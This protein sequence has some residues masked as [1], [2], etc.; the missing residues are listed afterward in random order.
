MGRWIIQNL[1]QR[2]LIY[3]FMLL[4]MMLGNIGQSWAAEQNARQVLY[5]SSYHRGYA[6]ND[7]IEQGL[8]ERIKESNQLIDIY[9]EFLDARRFPELETSP[10]LIELFISKHSKI[11]YDAIIVSDNPAINFAVKH[12][13]R[14]FPN[15]PIV[16][17]GY[18]SFRPE[19][20]QGV[21]HITGVNEEIDFKGTIDM[22][23]KVH[24]KTKKLVFVSSDFNLNG[25]IN[26]GLVEKVLIPHYQNDY[27]IQ[28]IKN[29][30]LQDIEQALGQLPQDS[31]VFMLGPPLDNLE[32]EVL[33]PKEYYHRFSAA[34]AVP[35]YS[36]WDF[37]LN[38]GSMGGQIITGLDQGRKVVDLMLELFKNV[39]IEQ[40][41]V[42]METPTRKI[43]DFNAMQRFNISERALPADSQI[44]NK[45]DSFYQQYK[46]YIFIVIFFIVALIVLS[47][48]LGLLLRKSYWLQKQLS[49][50]IIERQKVEDNLRKSQ[51]HLEERVLER[52]AEIQ[53]INESLQEREALFHGM[54]DLHSA[55]MF[56]IDPETGCIVEANRAA[57]NYYGYSLESLRSLP[58]EQLNQ[59]TQ[60][61]VAAEMQR[62]KN[63]HCNYFEFRHR[64]ATGE[65]RD[66]EVHAST[67][68]WKG[69]ELLF[70]IVHDITER[71]QIDAAL[72]S[73]EA[74]L[75]ELNATKDRLFSIIAHDLRSP[76]QGIL[77]LSEYLLESLDEGSVQEHR[78]LVQNIYNA[79]DNTF[80]LLNTLLDWARTQTNQVSIHLEEVFLSP[81]IIDVLNSLS[82]VAQ[83]KNINLNFYFAADIAV[84]ADKNML[85]TILR[86]LVSNA[87][88]YTKPQGDIEVTVQ[89]QEKYVEIA[90]IDNGVGMSEDIS[91]QLFASQVNNST[92]GTAQEKGTGLGLVICK[93]FVLKQNG[94]IW[95]E[96][97]LDKGSAFRFIL[98]R[99]T[100]I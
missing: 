44:I 31:L 45:P 76:F 48:V 67:V 12:R 29:R 18:N 49:T 93:D 24:P 32:H 83:H 87:I 89:A 52:T 53:R 92:Y 20:L 34:S 33:T 27:E 19:K 51:E 80:K 75:H 73:R 5:I 88:K 81:V 6:W 8:R 95:V 39:P 54:F 13:D 65:I 85:N 1:S 23:L 78:I 46:L 72:I 22:A 17:C 9:V 59:L 79:A 69:Q 64:L 21:S 37:T 7:G 57:L 15:T 43:F 4:L 77:G 50:E 70:S 62:A 10:S 3:R 66:V 71:K 63:A 55:V 40:I 14:I 41:P 38:T 84:Y 90:V 58:I 25:K 86:N 36:F 98:P 100:S 16:F 26:Q 28:Q 11:K 61:E 68:T 91:S 60:A 74:Q 94:T 82:A 99:A 97:K 56:L 42:V 30:Y 47:S 2:P 35:S 96:S